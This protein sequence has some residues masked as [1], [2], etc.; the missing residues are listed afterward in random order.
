MPIEFPVAPFHSTPVP[1]P[2]NPLRQPCDLL[3]EQNGRLSNPEDWDCSNDAPERM[4]IIQSSFKSNTFQALDI[5]SQ[6]NGFVQTVTMA[7]NDHHHLVIRPDDVWIAILSQFSIHVNKNQRELKDKFVSHN[8]QKKLV[9]TMSS[10]RDTADFG[11]LARQMSGKIQENVLDP[12]LRKWMT[13]NFTTTT[14]DDTV[15]CS[16][17]MMASMKSY[18]EYEMSKCGIPRVTLEGERSDWVD[19]RS[20]IEKLE[21]FGEE[22]RKWARLLRPIFDRFVSAF[23][24]DHD[25]DFWNKVS[26]HYSL[27][28]GTRFLSGWI[29]AFCVWDSEGQWQ[30]EPSTEPIVRFGSTHFHP[31][32]EIDNVLYPSIDTQNIPMGFCQVDVKVNDDYGSTECVMMSGHMATLVEGQHRDMVKPLPS[33]FIFVK[34]GEKKEHH[35]VVAVTVNAIITTTEN[36]RHIRDNWFNPVRKCGN[37]IEKHRTSGR[38]WNPL[39]LRSDWI[40]SDSGSKRRY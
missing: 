9:V 23:D 35:P 30:G 21:T 3:N 28:S 31:R 16:V 29:T 22:P 34:P 8:G 1:E 5:R 32:R 26:V 40:I 11:E 38:G 2:T 36:P 37:E 4:D 14:E 17:M 39:Y 20:R 7:Y 12:D 33:W 15:V 6:R 18:F 27:G 13:P 10:N 25:V 24:G 19:L